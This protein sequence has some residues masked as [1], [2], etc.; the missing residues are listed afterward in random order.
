MRIAT[1][2]GNASIEY[3][4]SV[5]PGRRFYPCRKHLFNYRD[6]ANRK[7]IRGMRPFLAR[8]SRNAG[9]LIAAGDQGALS[10]SCCFIGM[11]VESA[12]NLPYGFGVTVLRPKSSCT[13]AAPRRR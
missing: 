5:I 6:S 4:I 9:V 12:G 3:S 13:P 1:L 2:G 10:A 8:I 7:G 11:A